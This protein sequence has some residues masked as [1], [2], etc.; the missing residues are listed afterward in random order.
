MVV[1]FLCFVSVSPIIDTNILAL[2]LVNFLRESVFMSVGSN[3]FFNELQA[4]H[5]R[6][7]T[8]FVLV[9]GEQA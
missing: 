7:E 5:Q 2:V 3:L 9:H 1:V 6:C 4:T 8:M